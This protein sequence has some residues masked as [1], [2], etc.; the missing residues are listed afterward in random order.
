MTSAPVNT[1]A[2][3]RQ[4]IANA[5]Y[6]ILSLSEGS[7]EQIEVYADSVRVIVRRKGLVAD[8]I[9]HNSQPSEEWTWFAC[10]EIPRS[11]TADQIASLLD[12]RYQADRGAT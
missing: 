7:G 9:T 8:K 3:I 6:S 5:G 11:W 2:A 1:P 12:N 10:L 4:A